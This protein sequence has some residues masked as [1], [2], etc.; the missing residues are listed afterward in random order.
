M[1][2]PLSFEVCSFTRDNGMALRFLGSVTPVSVLSAF[3][4]LK[5]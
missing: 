1:G 2:S 4:T 3:V 5:K